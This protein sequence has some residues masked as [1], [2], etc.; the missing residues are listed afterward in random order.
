MCRQTEHL[1]DQNVAS[2]LN[3]PASGNEERC[4]ADRRTEAFEDYRL[5][6]QERS[7][8]K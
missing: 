7:S 6:E 8:K 2:F 1:P 5:F 4:D 3:T